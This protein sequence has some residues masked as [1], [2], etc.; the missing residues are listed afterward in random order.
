MIA[1]NGLR[2]SWPTI[3]S[4]SSFCG[5]CTA[6]V[7][8][9]DDYDRIVPPL[10]G[11]PLHLKQML[12]QPGTP[13]RYVYFPRG[14]FCSELIVLGDGRMVEVATIGREGVVGLLADS[15]NGRVTSATMV[16]AATG[17]S[18]RMPLA[19]LKLEMSRRG[20][21][22]DFLSR[23][24]FALIRIVMQST[25]CNAMHTVE[26]RLARW[27]LTA[28][29]HLRISPFPL[30]Q[31]LVAMML[32][33]TRTTVSDVAATLQRAGL[34]TYRRGRVTI[35]D[36]EGLAAAACECY[37]ITAAIVDDFRSSTVR[38]ALVRTKPL[39]SEA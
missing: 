3:A 29:D 39:T 28:E 27:L 38:A 21:F 19:A 1:A 26:Q 34:I 23:F 9:T 8:V 30:T 4:G 37:A 22:F 7:R 17:A 32:G 15:G 10:R 14:G 13:I 16:Q 20:A 12:H 24:R 33:V 36:R 5:L 2:N 25:A 11:G 31:D 6:C 18:V 35:V